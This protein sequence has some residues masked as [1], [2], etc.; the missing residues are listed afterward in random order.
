MNS[1][2]EVKKL[3]KESGNSDLWSDEIYIEAKNLTKKA[4][5]M[6]PNLGEFFNILEGAKEKYMHDLIVK[7]RESI[8]AK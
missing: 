2:D 3:L 4:G 6:M 8:L 5:K 7:N 1:K